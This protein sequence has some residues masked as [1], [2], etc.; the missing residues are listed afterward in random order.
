MAEQDHD[1][2]QLA[3]QR[4]KATWSAALETGCKAN[5]VRLRLG[6]RG[7]RISGAICPQVFVPGAA[8][9]E[10]QPSHGGC[11]GGFDSQQHRG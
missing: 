10:W 2:G 7:C 9:L 1:A 5:A 3:A 8:G 4:G 6:R 11:G